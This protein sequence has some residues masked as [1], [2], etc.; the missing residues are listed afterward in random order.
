MTYLVADTKDQSSIWAR[1]RIATVVPVGVALVTSAVIGALV[2]LG[3]WYVPLG[4][5]ICLAGVFL[6]RRHRLAV[7]TVWLL[8]VPFVV[9]TDSALV[10]KLFW[11]V[12]RGLP[13]AVLGIVAVGVLVGG[14][15]RRSRLGWPEAL[16]GG[17]VL[18]TV[19]SIVFTSDD[20]LATTYLFYDRIFIPVCLYLIIRLVE[21]DESELRRFVPIGVFILMSQSALGVLQW[22]NPGILPSAWL[23]L[24]GARTTG[25]LVHPNVFATALLFCGILCLHS[26]LSVSRTD[27]SRWGLMILFVLAIVMAFVTLS[28]ASWLAAVVVTAGLLFV[29][30]RA[31]NRL[32]WIAVPIIGLVLA[33]GLLSGFGMAA[34][35][36]LESASS[37]QSALSRLPVAVAAVRMF[38]ERPLVGWGYESFDR[39]DRRF[40][41][42]VAGFYPEKDQTHHNLFLTLLAEQGLLGLSLYLAPTIWWLALTPAALANM[43]RRGFVSRQL[44][45]VLWLIAASFFVV[46]QFSNF[47]VAFGFG[48]WW[49]TLGLIGSLVDRYQR[50]PRE[51]EPLGLPVG[52]ATSV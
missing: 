5:V 2:A 37:E 3:R 33:T 34:Q 30:P 12:H 9:E 46:N 39:F 45:I 15:P 31:L 14:R 43:P 26:A 44:L 40:Q 19:L 49:V 10:R 28:R 1:S 4:L 27:T 22:I 47:R 29:Y 11:V 8:V 23:G 32:A 35:D 48:L 52:A 13:V 42:T 21:P 16:I 36:R 7:I 51:S 20:A 41:T 50:R 6:L 25:S 17:Y 38:A 18:A 24:E